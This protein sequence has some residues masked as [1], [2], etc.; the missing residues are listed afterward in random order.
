[1]KKHP[2]IK[3]ISLLAVI[4]FATT[5]LLVFAATDN[6]TLTVGRTSLTPGSCGAAA[7]TFSG[8]PFTGGSYSP[9]GLTGGNTVA[10]VLDVT[11]GNIFSPPFEGFLVS[12][13]QVSGFSVDPGQLWLTSITCNG[14]TKSAASASGFSYSSGHATWSWSTAFGFFGQLVGTNDSCSITHN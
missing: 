3:R 8:Y 10:G 6:A 9:T 11:C 1:M 4:S 2:W 14:T 5:P 13:L 12:E 7:L